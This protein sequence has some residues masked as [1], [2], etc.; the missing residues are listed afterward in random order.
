MVLEHEK[1]MT[2]V[3]KIIVREFS[4]APS[5]RYRADGPASGEAFRDDLLVPALRDF[6][7][8]IIVLDGPRGY[9]SSFVD[10]AFAGLYRHG[11]KPEEVKPKIALEFTDRKLE[12]YVVNIAESIGVDPARYV[13]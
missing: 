6:D 10:E 12:T 3:K 4:P 2:N 11:L 5:G 1:E 13:Q 7:R 8:V 9:P